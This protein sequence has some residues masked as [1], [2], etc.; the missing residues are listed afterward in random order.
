VLDLEAIR[1]LRGVAL[2]RPFPGARASALPL[3]WRDALE[4]RRALL[5]RAGMLAAEVRRASPARAQVR[6]LDDREQ[7]VE[8]R[9]KQR[10]RA[11]LTFAEIER[12]APRKSIERSS[13]DAAGDDRGTLMGYAYDEAG[14][15]SAVLNTGAPAQRSPR[16]S[17]ASSPDAGR[18]RERPRFRRASATDDAWHSS[19]KTSASGSQERALSAATPAARRSCVSSSGKR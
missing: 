10:L 14:G 4:R 3:R 15:R 2:S 18:S 17:A 6:S 1:G 8:A 19:S 12:L 9:M 16:R 11:A 7:A 13:G 5:E